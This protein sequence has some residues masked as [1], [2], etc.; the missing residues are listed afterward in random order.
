MLSNIANRISVRSWMSD[1]SQLSIIRNK[2]QSNILADRITFYLLHENLFLK[3]IIVWRGNLG[4]HRQ[5]IR[6]VCQ[7]VN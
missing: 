7:V 6:K 5:N 2:F 4:V 3:A 1:S